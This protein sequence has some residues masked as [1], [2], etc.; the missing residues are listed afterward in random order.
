MDTSRLNK[1]R[2]DFFTEDIFEEEGFEDAQYSDWAPGPNEKNVT[3]QPPPPG[4][5]SQPLYSKPDG[6]K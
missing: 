5:F 6:S 1:N 3:V 2:K 4:D